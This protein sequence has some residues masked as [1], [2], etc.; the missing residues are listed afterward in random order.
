MAVKSYIA[1]AENLGL[2]PKTHV[3]ESALP[4]TPALGASYASGLRSHLT[5][6]L[7]STANTYTQLKRKD[8][9]RGKKS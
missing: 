7:T 9:L 8:T 5:P 6:V 3:R 2:G 4:I 1:L